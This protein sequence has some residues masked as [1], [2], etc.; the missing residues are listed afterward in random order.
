MNDGRRLL[1]QIVT[2]P[3]RAAHVSLERIPA[4][5]AQLA[6]VQAILLSR[7][8]VAPNGAHSQAPAA[9]PKDR[10]LTVDDAS[11][12]LCVSPRWLYRHA[13]SLPFA[14]RVNR[15]TLRFSEVGLRRW[16]ANRRP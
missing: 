14:H 10:Y 13:K 2:E 3:D 9:S 1:E 6:S 16:A 5:L 7:L 8:V 11:S 15:K 12:I 4:L